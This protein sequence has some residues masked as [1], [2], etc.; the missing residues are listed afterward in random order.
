LRAFDVVGIVSE[1]RRVEQVS[2]VGSSAFVVEEHFL[3]VFDVFGEFELKE[4][5]LFR[6]TFGQSH[7]EARA[8]RMTH[9]GADL[10][11]IAT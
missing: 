10:K 11:R 7:L 4:F 2:I 6:T 5:L 1:S 3:E 9:D 8:V